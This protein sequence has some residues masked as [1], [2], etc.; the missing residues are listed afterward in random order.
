[1]I[2]WSEGGEKLTNSDGR[3]VLISGRADSR[4]SGDGLAARPILCER[5]FT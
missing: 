4:A 2:G 3:M 1:M 5:R